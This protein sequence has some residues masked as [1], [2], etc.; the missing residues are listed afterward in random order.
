MFIQYLFFIYLLLT[1]KYNK[2]LDKSLFVQG[3]LICNISL[4]NV[5][6]DVK[7]LHGISYILTRK[8][9]QDVLEHLFSFLKGIAGS[10]SSNITSLDF[11]HWYVILL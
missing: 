5:L 3:I 1:S 6:Q 8:L 10:A 2:S 7:E 4:K 11:K 9:N